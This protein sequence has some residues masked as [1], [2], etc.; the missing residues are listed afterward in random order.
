MASSSKS[1]HQFTV[2][3]TKG[4]AVDLAQYKGK[5]CLI[6]NT[7]SKCGFT[8]Q[9]TAMTDLYRE[10]REEGF[11]ILAFPSNDF[12][13]Q[14]PL[15]GEAL[16]QFCTLKYEAEYSIFE[17]TQVKGSKASDLFQFLSSKKQNGRL[18]SKPKWNFHKYLIDKNGEVVDFFYSITSPTSSR[19]KRAI[20]KLL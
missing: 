5:V 9:L 14:E 6:V 13:G 2:K 19:V 1:I 4:Q 7:A 12:A 15:E 20:R 11:E 17:K 18:S 3:D 8:P 10:F 16:E